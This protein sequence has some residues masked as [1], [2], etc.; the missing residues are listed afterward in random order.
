MDLNSCCLRSNHLFI[1][2]RTTCLKIR[3]K[4]IH[5]CVFVITYQATNKQTNAHSLMAVYVISRS[6]SKFVE[7]I[8]EL[9]FLICYNAICRTMQYS[10]VFI[11]T[12]FITEDRKVWMMI[13]VDNIISLYRTFLSA[14]GA[15]AIWVVR[16]CHGYL[17]GRGASD[18]HMVQLM[19]L[20]PHY[21]LLY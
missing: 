8:L 11:V 14:S 16:Y 4:F 21:L 2:R 5:N 15:C 9:C 12:S 13:D 19:P 1:V 20:P 10:A 18:L 6:R 3:W 17:S 7:T